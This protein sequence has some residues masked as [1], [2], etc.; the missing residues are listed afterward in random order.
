MLF[1]EEEKKNNGPI[2][3]LLSSDSTQV[4]HERGRERKMMI[5]IQKN[6]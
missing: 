5:K 6:A 1:K 4:I 2:V 3:K